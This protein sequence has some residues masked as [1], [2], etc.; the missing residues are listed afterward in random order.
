MRYG[1]SLALLLTFSSMWGTACKRR[2]TLASNVSSPEDWQ[3]P[4]VEKEFRGVWI[5]TVENIDF[6]SAQNLTIEQQ[7]IEM[8]AILDTLKKYHFNAAL[9]Q[10]RP[11][12]DALYRSDIEPWSRFLTGTQGKDPGYDPL[13][14]FIQEAHARGIEVHAWLNPYRAKA[15]AANEASANH[16][17]QK[18][19]Q[20]VY[21]Y[22][23][24]EWMDPGA[25]EIQDQTYNVVIDLVKRYDLHGVHIDDYFYPYPDGTPFPDTKTY[26]A[27]KANGGTLKLDDWRRNNVDTLIERVYRGIKKTKPW[28]AFGI[29]PFGLYRPGYPEGTKGLDQYTALYADPKKWI[30]EKWVDY[31]AP[32]L[33]WSSTSSTLG[34]EKLLAWWT[35]ITDSHLIMSGH[36]VSH[37]NVTGDDYW[38][39]EE[40]VTQ[41]NLTR[42]YRDKRAVGDIFFSMRTIKSNKDGLGD[43]L[44]A[45]YGSTALPPML[46]TSRS[47]E[48]QPPGT[49]LAAGKLTISHPNLAQ[50]KWWVVY[51][52]LA[53]KDLMLEVLPASQ[54][55]MTLKTGEYLVTVVDQ[56][57]FE[58][59]GVTVKVP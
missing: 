24:L 42:K 12:A 58:S 40:I 46:V 27:Y 30:E 20:Y 8:V 26:E 3:R 35:G 47:M 34:F 6:P 31:S 14:F 19:P 45:A 22:R 11:E 13:E 51:Q 29:S 44:A 28:V 15:N 41:L 17:S 37:V 59:P 2:T 25:Q 49:Q 18:L 39:P 48:L 50:L 10:V 43:K 16:V 38:P 54:K 52:H 21:R 4:R 32:Q 23:N 36:S 33:Y 7:K 5:A 1:L 55:D 56:Y 9:F 53:D 57:G